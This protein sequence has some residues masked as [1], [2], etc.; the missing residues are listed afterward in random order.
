MHA[1][2]LKAADR[3]RSEATV[4]WWG[5]V[6]VAA[7]CIVLFGVNLILWD[8]HPGSLLGM[9]YGIAATVFLAGA[10]IYGARRRGMGFATRRGLGRSRA[11]L[12]FHLYGGSLFLLLVL[13]HSGFRLPVGTLN[14][15]LWLLSLWTAASGLGG[16]TLQRWIPRVLASGLSVEV[17]YDRIDELTADIRQ[18]AEKLA[19][20]CDD[21]VRAL[22][23]KIVAPALAAPERG[24]IFFLDPT[25][26]IQARLAPFRYL[27]DRLPVED[28]QKLGEL[29][30]LFRAKLEIDAHYT[31]QRALRGW[32]YFHAPPSL[33]LL[34]L[35]AIH[36]S[37]VLYY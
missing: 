29:E 30:R 15:G 26:G 28:R 3:K 10:S 35:V 23:K 11:W 31:L 24:L 13:M 21:S 12:Y 4:W 20:N 37:T 36:I 5:F 7:V 18:R 33:L 22:Y 34:A 9:S 25:G 27:E 17:N 1:R 14:W 6:V 32:L 8:V 16:L 19:E 2:S